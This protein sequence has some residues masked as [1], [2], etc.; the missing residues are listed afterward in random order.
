MIHKSAGQTQEA[1]REGV[2]ARMVPAVMDEPA[3]FRPALAL[4]DQASLAKLLGVSKKTLQNLY[5][6]TPHQLPVAIDIPG[7]RGPRW[8]AQS[9]LAWL[10]GRPTHTS[11]PA[12]VVAKRSVGRPRI[13]RGGK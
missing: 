4:Y 3:T 10:D 11:T 12:P 8:T 1:Y 7:A 9:I 2:T 6:R 5:S 13:A